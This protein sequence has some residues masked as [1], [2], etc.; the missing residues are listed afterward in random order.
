MFYKHYRCE[1]CELEKATAK[2]G[3]TQPR[4]STYYFESDEY[5]SITRYGIDHLRVPYGCGE[6]REML[7][8]DELFE[9]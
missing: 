7:L 1:H 8:E 4:Y 2:V 6:V 5:G 3:I 9:I